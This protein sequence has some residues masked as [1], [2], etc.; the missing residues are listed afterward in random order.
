MHIASLV[1]I[2][3]S[4]VSDFVQNSNL[5]R[6]VGQYSRYAHVRPVAQ[7]CT[8]LVKHGTER[9][10]TFRRLVATI[11]ASD[12]IVYLEC[13]KRLR[14]GAVGLTRLAARTAAIRYVRVSLD[15]RIASDDAVAI[16]G[17]ELYH[18]TELARAPHV[19]D[20][21]GMQE[22]YMTL[23]HRTCSDDP[24]C[25]DTREAR[26][27]GEMVLKELRKGRPRTTR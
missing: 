3:L 14:P 4:L 21:L 25:F 22:L 12:I 24:P 26:H 27:A 18:V 8:S 1:L 20:A 9:S 7:T 15:A 5:D 23:G 16:L 10:L 11:E 13:G 19:V 6:H 2:G 17:H